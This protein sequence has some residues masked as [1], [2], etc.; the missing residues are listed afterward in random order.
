MAGAV[1]AATVGLVGLA[2]PLLGT[3]ADSGLVLYFIGAVIAHLRVSSRDIVG[4]LIR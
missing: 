3:L 4:R 2:V 1:V